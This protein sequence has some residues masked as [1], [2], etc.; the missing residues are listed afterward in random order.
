VVT[1]TPT[2]V[3]TWNRCRRAWRNQYLLSLP[4]SDSSDAPLYGSRLHDVLRFVHERGRC[5][6]DHHVRDVLDA[7]GADARMLDE[8]RRHASRCPADAAESLG[9]EVTRAR[10]HREPWPPF[11]ATARYDA[12]WAHDGVLEARDYKTGKIWY[13]DLAE[14]PR[15]RLQAWVLAPLARSLGARLR[16]RYEYVVLEADE[17]PPAWEPD[18]D[19][20]AAVE[21][22]LRRTVDQI[23][24]EEEWRGVADPAVCAYCRYASICPDRVS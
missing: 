19:E 3:D 17:D 6:D 1:L 7:H 5:T 8:L 16:L 23:R 2:S 20:L 21:E 15:A 14:D 13:T 4:A 10:F 22:G 12:L 18:D 11:M 24:D 9:H